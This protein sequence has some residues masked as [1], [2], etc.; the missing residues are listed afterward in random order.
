[1]VGLEIIELNSCRIFDL[2][3]IPY[4]RGKDVDTVFDERRADSGS[5]Q[6]IRIILSPC[7][8]VRDHEE[9]CALENRAS[10]TVENPLEE[11]G[12]VD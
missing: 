12:V 6:M 7:F 9:E 8:E 5:R 2:N 1:M 4:G 3:S 10:G 11:V